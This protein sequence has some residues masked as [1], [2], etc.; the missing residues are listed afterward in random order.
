MCIAYE[1]ERSGVS[2]VRRGEVTFNDLLTEIGE[3]ERD[4]GDLLET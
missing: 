1:P 2:A 4:L 3:L